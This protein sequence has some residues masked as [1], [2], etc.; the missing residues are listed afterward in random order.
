MTSIKG[1][2]RYLCVFLILSIICSILG[3]GVFATSIDVIEGFNEKELTPENANR[4]GGSSGNQWGATNW[5]SLDDAKNYYGT[6]FTY[7]ALPEPIINI[8]GI[9]THYFLYTNGD[10]MY[11]GVLG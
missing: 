10:R 1:Y 4:C 7:V 6:A 8:F 11:F 5:K 2:E 3:I 9:Y